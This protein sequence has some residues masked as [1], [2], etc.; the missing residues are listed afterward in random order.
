MTDEQYEARRRVKK[1]LSAYLDAIRERKQIEERLEVINA[2]LTSVG[3]QRLDG[4]PRGGSGGDNKPDLLDAKDRLVARYMGIVDELMKTQLA[5]EESIE[6]LEPVE[7]MVMRHRYL[8]GMTWEQVCVAMD[9]SWRQTH[10][11]HAR[12]LDRLVE[13]E[14]GKDGH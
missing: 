13:R 4:M 6:W 7:R 5:I 3:S 9:Y 12:A 8:E 1:R 14:E 10:Y 2:R 11:I